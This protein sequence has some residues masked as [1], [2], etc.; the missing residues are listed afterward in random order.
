MS[1]NTAD[2][3][4]IVTVGRAVRCA[5]ARDPQKTAISF[6][7]QRL[8]YG[9]LAE[10]I[11]RVATLSMECWN[12]K[13]GDRV[14]LLAPNC[15]EYAEILFG[16]TETGVVVVTLN[17]TLTTREL[18]AIILDC[19]PR[20]IITHP[21]I[22][23]ALDFGVPVVQIGAQYRE[24]LDKA[25]AATQ[26]PAINE[27]D[28]F[29]IG[30]TSGTTGTPKGVV[31]SHRSRAWTLMGMGVEYNCFGIDDN[32]LL[33]TPLFHAAG[34][35]FLAAPL[36]FG[37]TVTLEKSFDL[38]RAVQA[39]TTGNHTGVFLVPTIFHR[40]LSEASNVIEKT[41]NPYLKTII[42]N[43]SALPQTSKENIIQLWGPD[44]LH[45]TYGATEYGIVT[46]IRPK[47]QLR[48]LNCVGTPFPNM[49]VQLRNDEGAVVEGEG[50]GAIYA[51]GPSTFS[52]YWR[53]PE[54]TRGAKIDEWV[55]VGD[56]ARRDSEGYYY[57]IDRKKDM[58]VSGGVNIY[59]SEIEKVLYDMLGVSECAV[60]GTEDPEWG[61]RLHAFIVPAGKLN[62]LDKS[63]VINH[64]RDHLASLKVPRE[65][66]FV[67]SLPKNATG[68][69]LKREL[70]KKE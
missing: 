47:D 66:S 38:E 22:K 20:L 50:V 54:E 37:A 58:V 42:S 43:A 34:F 25:R 2:K 69:I 41:P 56:I 59:P 8:P 33:L 57:I 28:P 24:L 60:I 65:I 52:E 29:V 31:L 6:E 10:H 40:I 64:C 46:N 70:R 32:F 30:Y 63:S 9:A 1:Y 44:R 49:E 13:A 53:N 18:E 61:E 23:A 45:E 3:N 48:K 35:V 11:A 68:K 19:E 7:G 55:T 14:I 12:L 26:F 62:S 21:D 39:L 16:L 67:E 17:P 51:R 4:Q 36:M 27:T 15:L 5:A